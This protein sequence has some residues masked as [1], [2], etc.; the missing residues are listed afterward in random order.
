MDLRLRARWSEALQG[1]PAATDFGQLVGI[2]SLT[3]GIRKDL[4]QVCDCGRPYRLRGCLSVPIVTKEGLQLL[5]ACQHLAHTLQ[6]SWIGGGAGCLGSE[7]G[8]RPTGILPSRLEVF[9][10]GL[11]VVLEIVQGQDFCELVLEFR[12]LPTRLLKNRAVVENGAE[13]EEFTPRL[14]VLC[15]AETFPLV[16]TLPYSAQRRFA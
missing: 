12:D 9:L 10:A 14:Q 2:D 16:Q 4:V 1:E 8:Q 11:P 3:V 6:N 5:K 13:A 7:F 15:C